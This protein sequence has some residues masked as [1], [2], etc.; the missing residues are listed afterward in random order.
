VSPISPQ[1]RQA[2]SHKLKKLG[3]GGLD[4]PGIFAQI[5]TLYRTHDAFR[6][7]LMSTAPDQRR[8][9]Y[10]SLRPHLCFT[11]KP[12]DEYERETKERAEKEQWDV[13]DG[14]VFPRPYKAG[15]IE[16]P[17]YRLERLAQEAIKQNLHETEGGLYLKC[18]KCTKG[19]EWHAKYRKDAE[20]QAHEAGWRTDGQKDYCP[21]C[22]PT[23]LTLKLTC[24]ECNDTSYLRAWD[25]QDA[26]AKARVA[27]WK[28]DRTAQC[29]KCGYEEAK[30][31]N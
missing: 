12:L 23:R 31:F 10:E 1:E 4:D 6:G 27:G 30:L 24:Q 28:I 13:Y 17:E 15:E 11:P 26:Y 8:V 9:A 18:S 22:V 19:G 25:A 21:A 20:K 3:F 2:I 5:A 14:T 7:L 29:P 16:S